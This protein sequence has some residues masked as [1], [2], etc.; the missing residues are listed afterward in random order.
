MASL[1]K[2]RASHV[3][4]ENIPITVPPFN[5]ILVQKEN[6]RHNLVDRCVT[7]VP[8]VRHH[9]PLVKLVALCV[10]EVRTVPPMLRCR[11]PH[12]AL[13]LCKHSQDR[14]HVTYARLADSSQQTEERSVP[15]VSLADIPTPQIVLHAPH[16]ISD[17]IV[18]APQRRN[19]LLVPLDN[20]IP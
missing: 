7:T 11:V 12:V 13:A 5:V 3:N 20:I 18:P 1:V 17:T 2:P 19:A 10:V 9:R 16:A 8:L 6:I 15:H 4:P 14:R